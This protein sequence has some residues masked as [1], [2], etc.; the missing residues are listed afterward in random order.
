MP[1]QICD[2][3]KQ[4][5]PY[6]QGDN[7]PL[8]HEPPGLGKLISVAIWMHSHR[9]FS[10]LSRNGFIGQFLCFFFSFLSLACL[11]SAVSARAPFLRWGKFCF[12]SNGSN[13]GVIF[14]FLSMLL[15]FFPMMKGKL[16]VCLSRK[17]RQCFPTGKKMYPFCSPASLLPTSFLRASRGSFARYP[18]Q[19][20]E[21]AQ[22]SP[23]QLQTQNSRSLPTTP[24]KF[25]K[26]DEKKRPQKKT[27]HSSLLLEEK[28]TV[29]I[30]NITRRTGNLTHSLVSFQSVAL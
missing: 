3:S 25:K 12:G 27:S 30:H 21:R 5:F 26:W 22:P 18:P 20:N 8:P 24:E 2:Q 10:K 7:K 4:C 29:T 11:V 17:A 1:R 19:E 13:D 16:T 14:S 28:L 6:E 9:G 23:L 15:L